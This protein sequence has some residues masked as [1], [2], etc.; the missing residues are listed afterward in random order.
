MFRKMRRD[1]QQVSE[2]VCKQLLHTAKRGVLSLQGDEGYPYGIPV[3][4]YYDEA[5]HCIYLHGA[6]EGHKIDAIRRCDKVC[7]TVW[8]E[9][10]YREGD[11]APYVTSVIVMGRATLPHDLA[12]TT[13][14]VR[15]MGL[16]YYPDAAEV[17]TE[18]KAAI[19]HVQ[20]IAISIEH[21]TGKQI[22]EK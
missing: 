4:F 9:G 13:E 17:E 12:Q 15:A 22:H 3:N 19:S 20:L 11:W 18:I 7:F 5:E 14:K 1:K 10:T 6:G 8:N 16:K 2:E 21:M